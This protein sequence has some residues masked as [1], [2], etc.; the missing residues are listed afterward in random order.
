M[1]A[2]RNTGGEDVSVDDYI[3][4]YEVTTLAGTINLLREWLSTH[5][6]EL[7]EYAHTDCGYDA[8]I[9]YAKDGCGNFHGGLCV[10]GKWKKDDRLGIWVGDTSGWWRDSEYNGGIELD[11][12]Q[13]FIDWCAANGAII[14]EGLLRD[15]VS[16]EAHHPWW[17]PGKRNGR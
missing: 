11:A 5:C 8:I 10:H 4:V 13:R 6:D 1:T 2:I 9:H 12:G 16:W 17:R 7:G 14:D 15:A 3:R